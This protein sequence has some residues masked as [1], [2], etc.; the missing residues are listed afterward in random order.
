MLHK[1]IPNLLVIGIL[2]PFQEK[3]VL[4]DNGEKVR[5]WERLHSSP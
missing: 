2:H 1:K 4:C 5:R 3:G